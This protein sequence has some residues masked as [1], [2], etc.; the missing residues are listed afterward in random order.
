MPLNVTEG[1]SSSHPDSHSNEQQMPLIQSK[2]WAS[3]S[4]HLPQ[5]SFP[6]SNSLKFGHILKQKYDLLLSRQRSF[7]LLVLLCFGIDKLFQIKPSLTVVFSVGQMLCKERPLLVH[8][9]SLPSS[10]TA[11]F[12]SIKSYSDK[13]Y[14]CIVQIMAHMAFQT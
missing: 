10:Q 12:C 13:H 5:C 14:H 9:Q 1:L 6:A 7:L 2:Y 3:T 4:G 8:L 11:H